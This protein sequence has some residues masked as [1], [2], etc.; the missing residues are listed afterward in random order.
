MPP[1]A[2]ELSDLRARLDP[3]ALVERRVEVEVE[4]GSA[5]IS[6]EGLVL[7][8]PPSVPVR[9]E[10]L[11]PDHATLRLSISGLEGVVE[12]RPVA[13]PQGRLRLELLSARAGFLP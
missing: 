8:L 3:A 11:A 2:V 9:V 10:R 6:G 1:P 4:G 12:V 13:T 7:L 5:R